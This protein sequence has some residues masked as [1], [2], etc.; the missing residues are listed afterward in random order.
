[1]FSEASYRRE[2]MMDTNPY[3]HPD[4]EDPTRYCLGTGLQMRDGST[5]H[6]SPSCSY[7]NVKLAIQ[8]PLLKTMTQGCFQSLKNVFLI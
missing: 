1:M 4:T 8:G 6:K 5:S 3:N 7:H 2:A